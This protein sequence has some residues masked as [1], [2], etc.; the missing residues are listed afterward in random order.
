MKTLLEA[1]QL[2]HKGDFAQALLSFSRAG[3]L[4][5]FITA[6]AMADKSNRIALGRIVPNAEE[7]FDT[8]CKATDEERVSMI[9]D[10]TSPYNIDFSESSITDDWHNFITEYPCFRNLNEAEDCEAFQLDAD[11]FPI[12]W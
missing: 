8:W 11:K 6:F 7:I 2:G 9:Q 4:Q 10:D 12:V 3:R 5:P 1:M